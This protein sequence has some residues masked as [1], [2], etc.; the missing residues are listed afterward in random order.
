M[1]HRFSTAALAFDRV[2][3]YIIALDPGSVISVLET[4]VSR[5]AKKNKKKIILTP[6]SLEPTECTEKEF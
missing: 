3:V 6:A 1:I 2:K 4:R 5:G